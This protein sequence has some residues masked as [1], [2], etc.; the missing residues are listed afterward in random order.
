MERPADI[1]SP[2]ETLDLLAG[3]WKIFQLKRGHR[4]STDD[5]LCAWAASASSPVLDG[6]ASSGRRPRLLDLGA[7]IGSVGLLTLWRHPPDTRLVMVEAQEISHRLARRTVGWNGLGDRVEARLGDLRDP[8]MVPEEG[9]F[10][11]V[12]CS[13]P[14]IPP[15]RGAVSPVPQ[16]A[17]ARIELRGS[18]YDYL[19][20][21]ARAVRPEGVIAIV[22]A[23]ED[24]RAE[25]AVARTG[26]ALWWRRDVCFRAG[27]APTITLL[28]AGPRGPASADRRSPLV[29][30]D[31]NGVFSAEMLGIRREMGNPALGA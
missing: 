17:G 4:F 16:R 22:F 20:V 12:T 25:D 13:P 11:V 26:L 28:V 31:A 6:A 24:P 8:E 5:L 29:V 27:R 19:Q 2:E 18:I 3:T 9:T 10:D 15:G 23:G 21:A 1:P 30:R 14:Y 7:G